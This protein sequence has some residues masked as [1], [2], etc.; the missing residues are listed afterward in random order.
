MSDGGGTDGHRLQAPDYR[1]RRL[2]EA[3][4]EV[5]LQL[6]DRLGVGDVD[7]ILMLVLIAVAD[8]RGAPMDAELLCEKLGSSRSTIERRLRPYLVRALVTKGRRGK[9]VVYLWT[10]SQDGEE[11]GRES[12]ADQSDALSADMARTTIRALFDI[13]NA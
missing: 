12:G 13:A 7:D 1:L 4:Y 2:L 10:P 8:L 3:Y 9:S 6:R 11:S 5:T